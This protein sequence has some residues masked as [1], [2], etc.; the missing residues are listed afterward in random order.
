MTSKDYEALA[1]D[2][3]NAWAF[4]SSESDRLLAR[5]VMAGFVENFAEYMAEENSRFDKARFVEA[6]GL[7]PT[8]EIP[9][10]YTTPE[11]FITWD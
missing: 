9:P 6:C 2:I 10:T 4:W 5:R 3:H 1:E 8:K 11:G 7:T